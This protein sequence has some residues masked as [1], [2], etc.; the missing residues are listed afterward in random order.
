MLTL[1]EY[2]VVA[3]HLV[4]FDDAVCR[5]VRDKL[6]VTDVWAASQEHWL[7]TLHNSMLSTD[8]KD[9]HEFASEFA[10]TQTQLAEKQPTLEDIAPIV[11]AEVAAGDYG[12]VE[13]TQLGT[14][15]I[16]DD[17]LPFGNEP[18]AEYSSRLG[19]ASV[20]TEA[21]PVGGTEA[22][23]VGSPEAMEALRSRF[24]LEQ[25]ASLSAEMAATPQQ[26]QFILNKY[27][28]ANDVELMRLMSAWAGYFRQYPSE[29]D[30]WQQAVHTFREYLKKESP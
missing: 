25:Y 11:E 13:A 18:S 6:G 2:A 19:A 17:V 23:D 3:A 22:V 8:M 15:A 7:S 5:E 29:R 26:H 1:R 10:S 20:K 4:Y 14:P 30:R 9:A 24:T 21:V 28:L 12:A 27:N 16:P